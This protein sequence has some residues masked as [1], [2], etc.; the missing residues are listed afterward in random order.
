MKRAAAA[1]CI[2]FLWLGCAAKNPSAVKPKEPD[3]VIAQSAKYPESVYLSGRGSGANQ[4]IAADRA[5]SDLIKTLEVTV[6][7]STLSQT[8][9]GAGGAYESSFSSQTLSRASRTIEGVEIADRW[10][11]AGR[12]LHYALAVLDRRKAANRLEEEMGQL[13]SEIGTLRRRAAAEEDGLIRLGLLQKAAERLEEREAKNAVIAVLQGRSAG[14]YEPSSALKNERLTALRELKLAV[15]AEDAKAR[16][17]VVSAL[18][19]AGFVL[20][21]PAQ[22]HYILHATLQ[23]EVRLQEGWHWSLL[24]LEASLSQKEGALRNRWRFEA[25]SSATNPASA[26]ERAERALAQRLEGELPGHLMNPERP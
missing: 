10:F 21:E 17:A 20:V 19:K 16:G 12:D 6:E 13:E 4:T 3:W 24:V 22:A 7:S 15:T 14:V 11:D 18:G 9:V 5:R 1:F 26:L 25:K 23:S 8:S 2:A